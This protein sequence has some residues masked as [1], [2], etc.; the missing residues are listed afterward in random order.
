MQKMRCQI[1]LLL[2][3]VRIPRRGLLHL[4]RVAQRLVLLVL[5]VRRNAQRLMLDLT[6][7]YGKGRAE[8][9]NSLA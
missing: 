8:K 7:I 4:R 3:L 6:L 9:R 2:M 5:V 1:D